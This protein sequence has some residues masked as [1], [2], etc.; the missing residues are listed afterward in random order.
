[1]SYWVNSNIVI[2]VNVLA[3][4]GP[5]D[6]NVRLYTLKG[7][8]FEHVVRNLWMKLYLLSAGQKRTLRIFV[9]HGCGGVCSTDRWRLHYH[10]IRQQHEQQRLRHSHATWE[11]LSRPHLPKV[12]ITCLPTKIY[13]FYLLK[14]NMQM[15]CRVCME[16][17]TLWSLW[18]LLS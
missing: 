8:L 17:G 4:N 13:M 9:G 6:C 5:L 3:V 11:S 15:A 14:N 2:V 18:K 10:C 16:S 1:M 7:W 12:R